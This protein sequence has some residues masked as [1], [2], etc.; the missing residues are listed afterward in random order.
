MSLTGTV[1]L[2]NVRLSLVNGYAFFDTSASNSDYKNNI[3]S[4]FEVM[5][6]AGKKAIGYIKSAGTGETY[7][8]VLSGWDFTVDWTAIGT[9]AVVDADSYS[10]TIVGGI[11]KTVLTDSA[12]YK[13]SYARSTTS[14]GAGFYDHIAPSVYFPGE[15]TDQY[16]VARGT[17]IYLRNASAGTTDV[18]TL[19]LKQVLTPSA[20][21]VTIVSTPGG[22]TYNWASIESGFNYNDASGY[23]WKITP[24]TRFARPRGRRI[25]VDEYG[26]ARTVFYR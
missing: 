24:H 9:G 14:S 4:Q 2:A 1:T 6:S 10:T 8:D 12:L 15:F 11:R 21:G 23:T 13:G 17:S 18:T 26:N 20:T 3:N 7:T 22:S 25:F 16:F 5:D 19:T